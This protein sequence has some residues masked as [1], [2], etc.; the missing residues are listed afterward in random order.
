MSH[1]LVRSDRGAVGLGFARLPLV[2][3][4]ATLIV[5]QALTAVLGYG[6][7]LLVAHRWSP[8]DVGTANGV[9]AAALLCSLVA[10][11]GLV[12]AVLLALPRAG[13]AHRA[14]IASA[15]VVGA[16]GLSIVASAA[17]IVFAPALLPSLRML[18]SPGEACWF[19]FAVAAQ[20]AG[21]V[22][23]A[24][25]IALR[26]RGVVMTR[27]VA[28]SIAKMAL[29]ATLG[30]AHVS[31]VN[32]VTVSLAVPGCMSV[33][34]ALYAATRRCIR[35]QGRSLTS[36]VRALGTG[37]TWH[38]LSSLSAACPQYVL[39]L[40]V[41]TRL[42]STENAH[43]SIAWLLSTAVFMVS[44]AVSQ[45]LLA[46]GSRTDSEATVSVRQAAKIT[47]LVLPIPLVFLVT[48]GDLLLSMFGA[49]YT[50]AWPA[51]I[52]L[53][54]GSVPDSAANILC[55]LLRIRGRLCASA[56][57]NL[58]IALVAVA[59]AWLV[60][61]TAGIA[62]VAAMW[63]GA[64]VIGSVAALSVLSRKANPGLHHHRK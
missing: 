48:G 3:S 50:A 58:L 13:E 52:V 16:V 41:T 35:G 38:Y 19:V 4:S 54:I 29:L 14:S 56:L 44:P 5:T 11:Q 23:D 32:A 21:T 61:P 43:F 37:V 24:A 22:V 31:A 40:I 6:Y 42:D 33:V 17:T 63:V 20:A 39:A 8:A 2:R 28:V 7:W 36:A 10:G 64:Q 59:G 55:A 12:P 25:A 49:G 62:Y 18:W 26:A 51:L 57:V 15:A 47:A 60:A 9:I 45:V 46:E 53:A 34:A 30:A 27:N 1:Q